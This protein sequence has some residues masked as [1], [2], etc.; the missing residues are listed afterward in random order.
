MS[1][2]F[3]QK[4]GQLKGR[5]IHLPAQDLQNYLVTQVITIDNK[6]YL[7]DDQGMLYDPSKKN[8]EHQFTIVGQQQSDG[9]IKWFAS[10]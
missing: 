9:T 1:Q 4:F 2:L 3:N 10:I 6:K 5:P 8:H 7:I